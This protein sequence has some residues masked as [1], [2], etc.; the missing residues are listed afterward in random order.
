[1]PIDA[2]RVI[3]LIIVVAGFITALVLLR[4]KLN[5]A[6]TTGDVY[7]EKLQT[8]IKDCSKIPFMKYD[9]S[10]KNCVPDCLDG[11]KLCGD[12]GCISKSMKCI[13]NSYLCKSTEEG[14]GGSCMNPYTHKCIREKIVEN[15]KVCGNGDDPITCGKN[16]HC[17]FNNKE[18][19]DWP[20][21]Q[22]ICGPNN[23]KCLAGEYCGLDGNCTKCNSTQTVCKN[24]CCNKETEKCS[25]DGNCVTCNEPLCKGQTCCHGD[26]CM[27]DASCCDKSRS[28]NNN[29]QCCA[30]ELC[31]GECCPSDT[32]CHNGKCMKKC[33]DGD[34]YCDI[35]DQTCMLNKKIDGVVKPFCITKGCEWSHIDYTP[36]DMKISDTEFIRACQSD[37]T[38][39]NKEPNYYIAQPI[40]T[41]TLRRVVQDQVSPTT[42]APCNA[43]DCSYRLAEDGIL[44]TDYNEQT[45]TCRGTFNCMKVLPKTISN[46]TCPFTNKLQCCRDKDGKFTGQVCQDGK[47]CFGGICAYGYTCTNDARCVMVTDPNQPH[48]YKTEEECLNDVRHKI[49]RS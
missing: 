9:S 1:M 41:S 6:C 19:I 23:N 46:D 31:N 38:G 40:D 29:T 35:N 17:T 30:R 5:K 11:E 16:Q 28:Y 49:C 44:E 20:D 3:I 33:G 32:E 25:I 24:K 4:N 48:A 22:I 36:S 42:H 27:P 37:A 39:T 34:L 15:N 8:C 26:T 2:T 12:K 10:V 43:N 14:C 45:K 18:C 47:S 7:D 13:D 21:D